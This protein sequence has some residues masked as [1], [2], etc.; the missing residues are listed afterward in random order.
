[1][2]TDN[3]VTSPVH[4]LFLGC[5]GCGKTSLLASMYQELDSKGVEKFSAEQETVHALQRALVRM[6]EGLEHA[7]TGD[8]VTE[9]L[10]GG[11]KADVYKF[12]AQTVCTGKRM[13]P[14]DDLSVRITCPYIFTDLP[15]GWYAGEGEHDAEVSQHLC[16]SAVSFL[17]IDAPAL[18]E[19]GSIHEERNQP[20]VIRNWYK[21][22]LHEL[23]GKHT[24]IIILSR[25]ERF[26]ND[27]LL[28]EKLQSR[29]K[30]EYGSLATHLRNNGIPV[31]ATYVKTLGGLSFNRYR[32]GRDNV[33]EAVFTKTG[34]YRPE[35]CAAPL[36]MALEYGLSAI[37]K[38]VQEEA[39]DV[40][41]GLAGWLGLS[42]DI[43]VAEG[44]TAIRD[45]FRE[46]RVMATEDSL[47]EV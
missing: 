45:S 5:R 23:A 14:L 43:L 17:T 22:N 6:K 44:V 40:W 7:K 33:R 3:K 36:M 16:R 34:D 47:L 25:C 21:G 29:M 32:E 24:V 9:G 39:E 37:Q 4:I 13:W 38:H 41:D 18:A 30:E 28:R 26:I 46:A 1:M 35:N 11:E 2:S 31:Y 27:P 42:T 8:E 12:A 10:R 19:G 20:M 15:G